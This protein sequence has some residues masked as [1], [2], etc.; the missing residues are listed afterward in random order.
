MQANKV[1]QGEVKCLTWKVEA[2]RFLMQEERENMAQQLLQTEQQL[3][4][5]LKLRETDHEVER[6][7]LLRDL[8][9]RDRLQAVKAKALQETLTYMTTILSERE[10]EILY[11]EQ[12]RT[13]EKQ[14][15]MHETTPKQVIT[16]VTDQNLESLQKQNQEAGEATE[17]LLRTVREQVEQTLE[18]L[19]EKDR[20]LAIQKQQTRSYE[21]K[22]EEQMYVLRKDLEYTKAILK[23]KDFMIESQK[24]VIETFQNQEQ[25]SEQQKKILHQLEVALKEKDQ[26]I[27]S[28]RKQCEA[29]REK[30]KKHEAEQANLQATKWTLK[31]REEK[32]RTL[33]E[34]V[35]KLQQQKE[36]TVVMT[37]A[38]QQK[39]EYVE[40][41]LGARDKEIMSLRGHVQD[42]QKQK[43]LAGKQARTLEQDL[44]K[45]RQ[46]LKEN[47]S[48]FLKQTEE[49][50]MLRLHTGSMKGALT[51]WQE[52]VD[53]LEK[54]VKKRDEDNETLKQKLQHHEEL[55]TL[56]ER[57]TKAQGEHK[58]LE[59][60]VRALWEDL[61][62]QQTLTRKDE[63]MKYQQDGVQYLEGTLAGVEEELRRQ[64]EL[65]KQSTAFQWKDEGD[66]LKKPAQKLQKCE[67]EEAEAEKRRAFRERDR[68][69]QM[70][71][72]LIQQLQ[73]ERK[74]KGKELEHLIS[75]LKQTEGR[76]LKWKEKAQALTHVLTK[77]EMTNRILR[78]EIAV[79]ESAASERDTDR[80]HHQAVAEGVQQSWL[81]E[82][83]LLSQ[84][85]E[86]LQQEVARLELANTE[87]KQFNAELKKT[88]E[89]VER[90]R[91]KLMRL[92][93]DR[94]LPGSSGSSFPESHQHKLPASRQVRTGADL[95][96]GGSGT[97]QWQQPPSTDLVEVE[98]RSSRSRIQT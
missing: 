13:L 43:E 34:A 59:E 80:F 70:Q 63:E 90:E 86:C 11:Q 96:G 93:R 66:T 9:E 49:I 18:T 3:N 23:E 1:I 32:I 40:S 37:K 77:S 58:K 17:M 21:I 83:K 79:L 89:E 7:K 91:R 51:S 64:S 87:M 41:S 94:S 8:H 57:E 71:K 81:L 73:D 35:S 85:L 82:K 44:E 67:E 20:L 30:E 14:K 2:E 98:Y 61:P 4:K 16:N 68:S 15:E 36:E 65:L 74:A 39:L 76:E 84:R 12:T 29:C 88:L 6:N 10:G 33:E 31:E 55:K 25:D 28:L 22:T 62:V 5:T 48:E 52:Q 97:S 26:E 92:Q 42:L 50:N 78:E 38:I 27:V 75:L 19:K 45:M 95:V 60:E 24:E 56:Q 54:A 69:L 46:R 47:N 72:E 53:L